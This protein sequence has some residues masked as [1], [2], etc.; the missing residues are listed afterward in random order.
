M[1]KQ[2]SIV[3]L[4]DWQREGLA[5]VLIDVRETAERLAFHIGGLHIP[6]DELV[7]RQA[8]I[9]DHLPVVF[10]CKRGIRSQLAIQRL[11][12]RRPTGDFYNLQNGVLALQS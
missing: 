5:F 3:E 7:R 2:L 4:E 11:L 6:L 9:P 12:S 10:Y 8:E 1:I